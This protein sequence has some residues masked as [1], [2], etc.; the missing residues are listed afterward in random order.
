LTRAALVVTP[1][2]AELD[3]WAQWLEAAGFL[4]VTCSG[5]RLRQSCPRLEGTRCLLRGAVDVAVV[6]IPSM[7][8][9]DEPPEASCTTIP[10]DGTTIFVDQ[11]G[12][13]GTSSRKLE[14]PS[15]L[16]KRKLIEAVERVL[17]RANHPSRPVEH[18]RR[19]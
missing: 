17:S 15:P 2:L 18:S 10:D 1:D 9:A 16:T 13:L 14:R 3:R 19:I 12:I 6:A 8:T 5:P 4:T 11:S 7:K